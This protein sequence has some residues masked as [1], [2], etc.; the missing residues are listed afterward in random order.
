MFAQ[1]GYPKLFQNHAGIVKYFTELGIPIPA[2]NA[3][4]VSGLE[5]FGG[6]LLVVGL[7]TR[8]IALMLSFSM[9]VATATAVIPGKIKADEYHNITD[10]FFVPEV[11]AMLLLFWMVFSG[12]GPASLDAAIAKKAA[13]APPPKPAA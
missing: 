7:G 3:W 2:F 4:F 13:S 6:M 11:L 9:F 10:A 8:I 5:F 1:A 12:P